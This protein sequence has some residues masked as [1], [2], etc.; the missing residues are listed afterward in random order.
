MTKRS[1]CTG[2]GLAVIIASLAY[3]LTVWVLGL[4]GEGY[5]HVRDHISELGVAGL[6][7]AWVLRAVLVTDAVLVLGLAWA[8][9]ESIGDPAGH[10]WAHRL[11][12]LFGVA[13]L[14]G[15]LFP[16][17]VD[18]EPT[19]L[20]G[21]LHV[22]NAVPSLVATIGAPFVMSRK[23]AEDPRLSVFATLSLVLGALVVAALVAAM[24]AFPALGLIGLGQRVVLAFQLCFYVLVGL[25][26]V[27]VNA[28]RLKYAKRFI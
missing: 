12:A 7:F 11:L 25:S 8:V 21:T 17:D 6:P 10:P 24:S 28:P 4:Q 1:A 16:C 23:L 13:L 5:S 3:P 15:G 18:C 9:R 27:H 20:A 26:V 2:I 19:S 22:L 14:V